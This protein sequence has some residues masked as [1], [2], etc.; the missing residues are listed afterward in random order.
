MQE[1]EDFHFSDDSD[2]NPD[3]IKDAMSLIKKGAKSLN[4][5]T[6]ISNLKSGI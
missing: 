1:V 2:E 6:N 5:I 4:P 3:M